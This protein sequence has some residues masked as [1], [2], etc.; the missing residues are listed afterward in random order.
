MPTTLERSQVEA[1]HFNHE[2]RRYNDTVTWLAEVL[3]GSMRTPFE[4]TF[5]G[6]ELYASDGSALEKIF[7]DS[8]E[9]ARSL[10]HYELRRRLI[11]KQ[12]YQ[13]MIAMMRGD[14]PNTIVVVSDFPPELMSADR[15]VGGYNVERRQTM[16]RVLAK[17]PDGRLRMYSQSLDGSDRQ[18][19]EAIYA[20]LSYEAHPGELLGQRM[21][22]E[23]DESEQKVLVDKLMGVYDRS[24]QARYGGE[25]YA[26]Q[27]GGHGINTYD[28]VCQQQG[29]L[30]AYLNTTEW[31]TGGTADYDL[32]AAMAARYEQK[33]KNPE[34]FFAGEAGR[35]EYGPAIAAHQMALAEMRGAGDAA[36]FIGTTYSGCGA[37]VDADK[38]GDALTAREQLGELGYGSQSNKLSDDKYGSRTF[39]CPKR[40][41]LNT[42]PKNILIPKCQKCGADVSCKYVWT[43]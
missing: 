22:V 38:L 23:L 36:R 2:A 1:T 30:K 15:D 26:G 41:C 16:L 6:H 10:P 27:L 8:I 25:W 12:E 37:S 11:E 39:K 20:S 14:R 28:F 31:F 13:E 43:Y 9:Q 42:R 17:T 3:P 7:D 40:G 18:A 5:D 24:L 21:H 34:A 33:L 35:W 29:L 19:L 32:A 4:Y